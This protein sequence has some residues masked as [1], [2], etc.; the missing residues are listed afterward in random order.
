MAHYILSGG[1]GFIGKHLSRLLLSEGH[2]VVVLSTREQQSHTEGLQYVRWDTQAGIIHGQFLESDY[3]IIN[4][5]GAGVAEQRWTAARKEEIIQSRAKS[6]QTLYQAIAS[7]QIKSSHLVSASA[8]G[9][10]SE[11]GILHTEEEQGDRSFLS[12][13]CQLWEAEAH[14]FEALQVKVAIARIGIVLGKEGGAMAAFLKTVRFGVAGIPSDGRQIYSWIHVQDMAR[15]L[16][17][18]SVQKA[19]GTYNAVAPYPVSI[20]TLFDSML[21]YHPGFVVKMHVPSFAI[22]MMLGEM[23][24]EVLKSS[25]VSAGKIMEA[26]FEFKFPVIDA[27][28]KDLMK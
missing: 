12:T 2:Q 5:A 3:H 13:T 20:N 8:I 28:M 18:L 19:E 6:L 26:G 21:Q 7:G 24:V 15:M 27:C 10:Y 4:L 14:R 16:Y 9:F 11:I 17:Y 23:A 25:E 22:E 1:S